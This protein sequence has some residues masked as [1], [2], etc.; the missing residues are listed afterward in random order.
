MET[1]FM[2]IQDLV[3]RLVFGASCL[4]GVLLYAAQ[5]AQSPSRGADGPTQQGPNLPQAGGHAEAGR[6]VFRFE[7][8]GNEGF[9]TD[10]VRV[11]VGM[12]AAKVTPLQALQL[13][14]SVDMEAMDKETVSQLKRDLAS[15]S[16]GKSSKLLNDPS[17]TAILINANA[18]IGM[19]AKDSDG[20]G[21]INIEKGD[22]V[23]VTCALCHTATDN[24]VF[25]LPGGGS[26]GR[27]LDGRTNHNLDVGKILATAANS[28]ALLPL[29]QLK[30]NANEG[31]TFGR[32]KKGI[33][34]KSTEAEVDAYLSNPENYPVGMFDDSFDGNGD[35]MHITPFFRQDLAAPYGS[36]GTF[37]KLENFNNLVFTA[38]LD[39]TNLTTPGGRAFLHKLG[40]AAG[41]EI[42]DSYVQVLKETGVKGYPFV[43]APKHQQ[44]GTEEAPIGLRVDNTKL[45]DLNAYL[46][47]LPAPSATAV[48]QEAS[49]RG[50]EIFRTSGCTGCHNVDQS[51][52]VPTF[53]VPM[54]KIFPGDDPKVLANREMPLNPVMDTAGNTFDDKMAV[55]N[56]S[57]RKE[58]R[59]TALPLLLDL[60]RKPVFLHDDSVKSMD[61]LFNPKRGHDA[62]HPFYITDEKE[63]AAVIAFLRGLSTDAPK[64]PVR[65]R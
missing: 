58:Q 1:A 30:L 52:P 63:R 35:P 8:F 55:V 22:K 18:V 23:G 36:E 49:A 11:P 45:L 50:K 62:P 14:I 38:L 59:G 54:K 47:S 48:D 20:D 9:W 13:G 27:R 28:R 24:A 39:P 2:R 29:L 12:K 4:A 6:D 42:T 7:T 56:A 41:D 44:P 40:G 51:K 21:K 3:K 17:A 31:K 60:A 26:I 37:A 25:S 65:K 33:T 15:D 19:A 34:A 46:F 10:A 61:E 64:K 5:T 43:K 32:A 53:I 57:L 16:T